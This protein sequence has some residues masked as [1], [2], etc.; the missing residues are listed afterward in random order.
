MS[1]TVD[2]T[3]A[4]LPPAAFYE[5]LR[6]SLEALVRAES[7]GVAQLANASALIAAHLTEVNWVGFYLLKRGELV[8][9]PFQGKPA[10][11]RIRMGKGVCGTAALAGKP[12]VVDDV[13]AFPGHIACDAASR[14]EF[15]APLF[16]G[17]QLVGVLDVDSPRVARF[18]EAHAAG[19]ASLAEALSRT[20]NW[21]SLGV[22]GV[23]A[24]QTMDVIAE[25]I[26]T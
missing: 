11:T 6:A 23:N 15:V 12:I 3:M 7:D 4:G 8:V 26:P 2:D 25:R 1:F 24:E 22:D 17:H 14:S 20:V 21:A 5:S 16:A 18:G 9:G 10:C 19:L 13:E